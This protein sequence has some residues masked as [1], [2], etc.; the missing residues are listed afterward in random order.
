MTKRPVY[1]EPGR[2]YRISKQN[3]IL[4]AAKDKCL[5]LSEMINDEDEML[6]K[7]YLQ[8]MKKI[9]TIK[10]ASLEFYENK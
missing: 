5:W 9:A 3:G 10:Q 1:G 2:I 8:G 4:V 7:E 6:Q